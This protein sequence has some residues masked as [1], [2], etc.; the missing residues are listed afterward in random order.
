M[1]IR[2]NFSKSINL[3]DIS[4]KF[5]FNASYL[6]KIFRK[7]K[8][9][10]PLKCLITYRI[11]EAKRLTQN[12]PDLD[13]KHIGEIVGYPD[14]AYFSRIFKNITGKSPTEYKEL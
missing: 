5:N 11:D 6:T 13:I 9:E 10:T 8:G 3:E 14:Q 7:H 12:Q 4:R 2:A 1:F